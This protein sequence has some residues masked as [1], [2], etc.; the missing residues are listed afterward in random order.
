M[1]LS[2][3]A[4]KANIQISVKFYL[5]DLSRKAYEYSFVFRFPQNLNFFFE[6][7]Y[8]SPTTHRV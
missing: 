1:E 6:L 5:T 2:R 4:K 8:T 7:P 3:E